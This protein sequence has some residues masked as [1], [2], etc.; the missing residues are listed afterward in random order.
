M[1]M[2]NT[3]G[4]NQEMK[5]IAPFTITSKKWNTSDWWRTCITKTFK[6]WNKKIEENTE[7]GKIS[8][9]LTLTVNNGHIIRTETKQRNQGANDVMTQVN[10]TNTR[11]T[12][13][14]NTKEY[15]FFPTPHGAFS[16]IDHILGTQNKY[17]QMKKT[18][19]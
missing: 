15:T 19:Q 6:T 14:P 2:T 11:K 16:K 7:D 10:L 1:Q 17:Q 4:K 13:Q 5:E 12:F 8:H 18:L 3:L 9:A